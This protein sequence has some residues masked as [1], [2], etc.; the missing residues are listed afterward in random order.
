MYI[1]NN[2]QLINSDFMIDKKNITCGICGSCDINDTDDLYFK[3]NKCNNRWT[4]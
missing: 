2:M 3:C 1:N 4:K